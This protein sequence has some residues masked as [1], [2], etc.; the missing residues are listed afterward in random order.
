MIKYEKIIYLIIFLLVNINL[1]SREDVKEYGLYF[2]S[3]NV[4][5][6]QRTSLILNNNK[7]FKIDNEITLNFKILIRE[8]SFGSI[9]DLK[10]N[11]NNNF[12][13][14]ISSRDNNDF[15]ILFTHNNKIDT[16]QYCIKTNEWINISLNLNIKDNNIT[17][18][19]NEYTKNIK[20]ELTNINSILPIFG[21]L[22]HADIPHINIKDVEVFNNRE[23]IR[24]WKLYKHNKD[25]CLDE[26]HKIPAIAKNP[27]WLINDHIEWKKIYSEE[28]D[29]TLNIAF[30]TSNSLFYLK[31]RNEI[32]VING[33]TG[34]IIKRFLLT[35][36]PSPNYHGHFIFDSATNKLYSYSIS[37]KKNVSFSFNNNLWDTEN[38][39]TKEPHF[40]NHAYSFNEKD[41][42]HYFF[43]G[44]GFY[45][46]QNKIF[47]FN[48]YTKEISS[49][50]YNPPIPPRC[51]ASL[52]I[53]NN[54]LYI[55]GGH[56]N[57]LGKQELETHDYHDL[58]VIDLKTRKCNKLWENYSSTQNS[59]MAS[60]MY[61]EPSDSSFY[62][63]NLSK[64][65][66]L[67]K[68]YIKD[69]TY[70]E[71]S[72][73]IYNDNVYQDLDFNLYYSDKDQK[74]FLVID[75]IS[76]DKKHDL[77]I[78]SINKPLIKEED[79][80]Q[81]LPE[82][83]KSVLYIITVIICIIVILSC[84]LYFYK[85]RKHIEN[86]I[87]S[88]NDIN[89]KNHEYIETSNDAN[90]FKRDKASISLL[91]TFNVKDKNG[92][93]ITNNFTPRIKRLLL[94]IILYTEKYNKGI[95]IKNVL[96]IIWPDKE[97]ISARNNL[98]VNLR[99]LRLLLEEVG[100]IEIRNDNGFLSIIWDNNIFCDYC[101][102]ISY[103][104]EYKKQDKNDETY[105]N[106]IIELL[107]F[108]P[109]L[110]NT[111]DEWLDDFK[112]NYSS[113]SIDLLT[114]LLSSKKYNQETSLHIIDIIFLHD[115]LNE[116][117]LSAKL[118][119]LFSQ[120]KKGLATNAYNRFCKEYKELLG[121]EYKKSI[122]DL[123]DEY[124]T[125][126]LK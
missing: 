2:N 60:S 8:K 81:Q 43:G 88:K 4:P 63:A 5:T 89:N 93:D 68:I 21:S 9:L 72:K 11:T 44:Y 25:I 79:I 78:Y 28:T 73:P 50:N 48:A 62:A 31:N 109:L 7:P 105:I 53:V 97:E 112:E 92:N 16:I 83:N 1:F 104:N 123:C 55:Y 95:L 23:I 26:L 86:K 56:G 87:D 41:S 65:G 126:I 85:K 18:K 61:F 34:K 80:I 37:E 29:S 13:L 120:G 100:N 52:A 119:I 118:S 98:N 27:H 84:I 122:S 103:I 15:S 94:I 40:N 102:A 91:G 108:G 101:T 90:N 64:G 38:R 74:F 82:N 47:K 35:N 20:T 69:S 75:K 125:Q 45:Q 19:N 33:N 51:S 54:K 24:N 42:S 67:C 3:Y 14:I 66:V 110:S 111:K 71:I 39:L 117:A 22:S 58:Y 115:P 32:K 70:T 17:I 46:Y 49:I 114:N 10:T 6:N 99:K 121:E 77:K 57:S 106:K 124:K 30:D 113:L 96:D 107:L 12:H 116:E 36:D 76:N 59:I